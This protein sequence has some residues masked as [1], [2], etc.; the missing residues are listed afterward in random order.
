MLVLLS[1]IVGL[2]L[3][4]ECRNRLRPSSLTVCLVVVL[5]T[6]HFGLLMLAAIWSTWSFSLPVSITIGGGTAL[7]VAG[8]AVYLSALYVFGLKRQWGADTTRLVTEGIY[9]WSRNP[10]FLGWTLILVGIELIRGSAMVL[11]LT[12]FFWISYR[13]NLPLEEELLGRLYGKDY[14][15]YRHRTHRYFGPPKENPAK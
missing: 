12:L 15:R 5:Y 8:T 2:R 13:L 9:R 4:P 11:L 1:L 3:G 10:L 14:E 6:I 7:V